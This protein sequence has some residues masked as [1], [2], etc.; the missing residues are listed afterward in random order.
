MDACLLVG[1][2]GPGALAVV[3]PARICLLDLFCSGV[4][5]SLLLSPSLCFVSFLC[6]LGDSTLMGWGSFVLAWHQCVLVHVGLGVGLAHR[7][8][9]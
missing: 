2:L 5:L 4:R 9:G 1:L 8:A 6:V 3:R 7:G